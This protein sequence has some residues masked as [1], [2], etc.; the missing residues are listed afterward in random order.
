MESETYLSLDFFFMLMNANMS[1]LLFFKMLPTL[2][3]PTLRED[4]AFCLSYLSEDVVTFFF[5]RVLEG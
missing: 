2:V 1:K 3:L 4:I 5:L